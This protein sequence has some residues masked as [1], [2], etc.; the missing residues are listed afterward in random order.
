MSKENYDAALFEQNMKYLQDSKEDTR[1]R[2]G[3]L[4]MLKAEN[5][6]IDASLVGD[7]EQ[8][9]TG[10]LQTKPMRRS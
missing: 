6:R 5:R 9:L 1:K 7:R 3:F 10:L 2:H 4:S 8:F